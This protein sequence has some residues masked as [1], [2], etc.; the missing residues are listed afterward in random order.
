MEVLINPV[1]PTL[2]GSLTIQEIEARAQ[3]HSLLATLLWPRAID[4]PAEGEDGAWQVDVEEAQRVLPF[5][6][7]PCNTYLLATDVVSGAAAGYVWWKHQAGRS[8]AEWARLYAQRHRP[9]GMNKALMDATSGE[10]FL[11]GARILGDRPALVMRELYVRP[12]CQRKGIGA[13][14]VQWGV[15]YAA[16]LGVVA[17]TEASAQGKELYLRCGFREVDCVRVELEPWGGRKG[18][19]S[20]YWLLI[21]D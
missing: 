7:D 1:P 2:E 17:Y 21:K 10:R 6:Q 20:E 15:K 5:L 12:E 16:E 14:L 4:A 19:V 13:R 8:E 9:H 11:R 18:E 3:Q